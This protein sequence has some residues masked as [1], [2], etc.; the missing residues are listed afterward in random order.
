MNKSIIA[1]LIILLQ[2]TS[3][4][5]KRNAS[6]EVERTYHLL[7]LFKHTNFNLILHT[8][9]E[10]VEVS[11]VIRTV[12]AT[13]Y[14]WYFWS[15]YQEKF[16]EKTYVLRLV[17]NLNGAEVSNVEATLSAAKEGDISVLS[18]LNFEFPK[19][20]E[21]SE[22]VVSKL[23]DQ[24]WKF[25]ETKLWEKTMKLDLTCA[26]DPIDVT[27]HVSD[28][29]PLVKALSKISEKKAE[30]KEENVII[31]LKTTLIQS[32]IVTP[33]KESK[34]D[35][36]QVVDEPIVQEDLNAI[37]KIKSQIKDDKV[38]NQEEVLEQIVDGKKSITIERIIL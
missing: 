20:C 16:A 6:F 17:T 15:G 29:I 23:V 36:I 11:E 3:A 22:S 9:A 34:L 18:M 2:S 1:I 10:K 32:E 21:I 5:S 30:T 8:N 4:F 27:D 26:K 33:I 7:H 19:E 24:G 38:I 28:K 37:V 13:D 31:P 35:V 25:T 14:T 12:A